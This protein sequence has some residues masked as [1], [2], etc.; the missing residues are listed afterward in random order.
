MSNP[1]LIS[2]LNPSTSS[3]LSPS[4]VEAIASVRSILQGISQ[5]RARFY[6]IFGQA[7]GNSFKASVAETIRSQWSSGDFSQSPV[8]E[9]L[10]SGMN[11]ALGAYAISNNRIYLDASLL[12][13]NQTATLASV[14]LEEIGHSVDAQIN[15]VDTVGDEGQLF[16]ALARGETLTD[17]QVAAIRAENDAGF[18]TVNGQSVAVEKADGNLDPSFGSGG[19]A[20]AVLTNG[21][22]VISKIKIQADGKIIAGGTGGYYGNNRPV[23]KQKQGIATISCLFLYFN[24][25][26]NT[27]TISSIN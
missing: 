25:L 24:P 23:G 9:I 21:S 26:V 20:Q 11:G 22:A 17:A 27:K 6:S 7:F 3:G 12:A 15:S 8:I 1:S 18:V 5:N 10:D 19:I 2:D 16:S 4:L 14:L 13:G